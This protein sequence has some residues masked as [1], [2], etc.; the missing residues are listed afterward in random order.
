MSRTLRVVVAP[1]SFGGALDSVGVAASIASGWSR[2]R[3]DD[4]ILQRPMADGG[5]GTL[6]AVAAALGDA[7][8]RRTVETTDALGRAVSAD[9]LLLDGG[10]GAFIEMAAASGLA[11]LSPEERTPDSARR[12]S[13]RGTGDLVRAA[14][15]AGV[16]RITIGLGGSATTDGGS[17]LL[18]A[19]GARLLDEPGAELPEGG[20]ALARLDRID[21]ETLDARLREVKIVIASDVTNPLCGQRGAAAT[22]GPQ[23]GADPDAVAELDA[24]L[25]RWGRAIEAATGRLV[26]DLPGAGAAGGT[27][28]GLLGLTS[29]LVRPGVEVVAELVGLADALESADLVITGEGR[30]DEQTLHGKTAIGV[31]TLAGPRRTPVVLLCGGLGPGAEALDAATSLTVVQ[32]IVDRPMDLAEAMAATDRLLAAAAGRLARTVGIGLTQSRLDE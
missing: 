22:Y 16:E 30:A 1:D 5:E 7:A 32:P 11:R 21:A 26:A 10:R 28:A 17:G 8:E 31:A 13:T 4:E 24:A 27:T 25:A 12:A 29:A 9:W 23:K 15:D 3:P 6:A 18:R 20:A 14:L 19:L 2:A